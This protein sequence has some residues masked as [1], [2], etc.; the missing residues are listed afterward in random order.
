MAEARTAYEDALAGFAET[1]DR[2]GQGTVLRKLSTVLWNEGE[3]TRARAALT[4][5]I[6]LLESARAVF[7]R[8]GAGPRVR[9]AG[10]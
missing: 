6:E 3:T 1:N 9:G 8:L 10:A 2:V 4:Q 7:E 5:A